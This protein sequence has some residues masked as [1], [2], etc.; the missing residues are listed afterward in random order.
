MITLHYLKL[1]TTTT[2]A[3]AATATN[4]KEKFIT[5]NVKIQVHSSQP[6]VQCSRIMF[7]E[8][9]MKP[10]LAQVVKVLTKN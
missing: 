8:Y 7:T 1:K 4:V 10:N 5:G 9:E 6:W 2:T 3:A